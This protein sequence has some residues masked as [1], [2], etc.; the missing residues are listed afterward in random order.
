MF[1]EDAVSDIR[2]IPLSDNTISRR[3][4]EMSGDIKSNV[5]SKL[6]TS[7]LFALQVDDST[8]ISGK[9]QLLAFV[10]FI[11]NGAIV[12]DFFC[13]KELQET[14]KGQ[15]I[16]DVLNS[17]LQSC[18]MTWENCIGICTDGAPAMTGNIKG[19]VSLVR[20]MNSEIMITHCFLHR[21]A[22]VAK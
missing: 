16:Y 6:K 13:C 7:E 3:I 20:Q 11:D 18:E 5:V 9:S 1:G 17:Y 12:E 8:D 10:R 19:F 22:L 15:D 4:S 2:K 14:T 21:E